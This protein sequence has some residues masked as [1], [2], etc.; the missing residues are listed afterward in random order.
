MS[1]ED[2]AIDV[3]IAVN[4]DEFDTFVSCV[5]N[6]I[7]HGCGYSSEVTAQICEKCK[8]SDLDI[9]KQVL[10]ECRRAGTNTTRMRPSKLKWWQTWRSMR[11]SRDVPS[12]PGRAPSPER[13]AT[14]R[15]PRRRPMSPLF[16]K[17]SQRKRP[18]SPLFEPRGATQKRRNRP[19]R[20]YKRPMSPMFKKKRPESPV[21]EREQNRG[22]GRR[23]RS[24]DNRSTKRQ[25]RR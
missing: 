23:Y 22:Y 17:K 7:D 4:T 12:W 13:R 11:E 10:R 1:A 5:E 18:M 2:L 14:T 21:Y 16:E 8:T 3:G 15:K 25:R 6:I 24:D 19:R 9:A 20:P